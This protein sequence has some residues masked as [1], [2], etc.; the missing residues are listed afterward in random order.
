MTV[1]T[2]VSKFGDFLSE[3]FDTIGRVAEDDRLVDL[4]FGEQSVEAVDFL[5][6]FNEGIILS[7]TA[8]S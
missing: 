2:R 5:L 7:N 4:E 3:K 1:E 6:L 8:K